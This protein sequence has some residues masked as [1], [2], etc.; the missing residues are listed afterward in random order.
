MIQP[1]TIMYAEQARA[2]LKNG[3]D[4]LANA[5]KTTLGPRGRN[6][7]IERSFGAPHVTK[8]GVTVARAVELTNPEEQLGAMM[9]L[10]AATRTAEKAGDGTTTATL[11]AQELVSSG[12]E[13]IANGCN[14]SEL[15]KGVELAVKRVVAHLDV[16]R[17]PISFDD[18]EKII[19]IASISANNNPEVGKLIADAMQRVGKQGVVTIDDSK[20]NETTVT[21]VEGM[22]LDRGYISP[23]FATNT[24]LEADLVN[25]YVLIYDRGINN[26]KS[27]VPILEQ[28]SNSGRS[29]LIIANDVDG[30]ALAGLIVN[31]MQGRLKVVAI[32]SPGFGDRRKDIL[33]DI[34]VLTNAQFVS[35]E[36]NRQLENVTLS[37][38]GS[39][40]RVLVTKDSTIISG[41]SGGAQK[42]EERAQVIR[43]QIEACTSDYDREKLQERL[44]KLVGGVGCIRV[45]AASELELKEKKDLV[46][47]ALHATRAAIE[48]GIVPGGGVAFLRCLPF[49]QQTVHLNADQEAGSVIVQKALMSP[50]RQIL[51]NAGLDAET[52]LSKILKGADDFG[53]NAATETFSNLVADGVIDPKKVVRVALENAASVAMSILS[54]EATITEVRDEHWY[55]LR[56][57]AMGE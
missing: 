24:K 23:Y 40:S 16:I 35:Q 31:K 56:T 6:V 21:V 12:Q 26:M 47:D 55:K 28:I 41:G 34:A 32:K 52:L 38:L 30:D 54:T 48:E 37:Y 11:L 13:M 3:I 44:S 53:Y 50:C 14:P 18:T 20:T 10:Q 57:P 22:Q 5:V 33:E 43:T 51:L 27:L 15:R 39:A 45:G 29:L 25:P 17:Q 1:K 19:N 49:L 46:E 42:I 9:V 8:D 2:A 36:L 4:K 7:V